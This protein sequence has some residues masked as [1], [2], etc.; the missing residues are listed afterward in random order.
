MS[1]SGHIANILLRPLGFC[2]LELNP[3]VSELCFTPIF[4]SDAKTQFATHVRLVK[5]VSVR[6]KS[7]TIGLSATYQKPKVQSMIF[8]MGPEL[9]TINFSV[10]MRNITDLLFRYLAPDFGDYFSRK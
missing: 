6:H 1:D 3:G 7:K 8:A 2:A 5:C 9:G 4:L 10:K